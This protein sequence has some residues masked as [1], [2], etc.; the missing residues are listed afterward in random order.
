MIKL[1][2]IQKEY[3]K[4]KEK[5]AKDQSINAK[6]DL[7]N[8]LIELDYVT[9][10]EY[11][12]KLEYDFPMTTTLEK[13]EERLEKLISFIE[14]KSQ[15]Q[16]DLIIEYKKLTGDTI[17]LSYL[18]Y[19]DNIK[20]YKDRLGN[21][22]KILAIIQDIKTLTKNP[23]NK[24]EL[25]VKV[26][27]NRLMKKELQ[28]LLYEF[29]LID[30]LDSKEIELDRLLQTVDIESLP[31]ETT[32]EVE[33]EIKPIELP[34]KEKTKKKE[35]KEEEIFVEEIKEKPQEEIQEY[36]PEEQEGNILT[37]MPKV[38][39]IGSVVPVNVYESLEKAGKKL[40][41]V[42]LPSNG[43]KDDE[44]DIFVDTKNLF[45]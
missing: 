24:N 23:G 14:E 42:V 25:R 3:K 22:R 36:I 21:V 29:C 7:K 45:E 13:E 2:T 8:K 31:E 9:N 4:L 5:Y 44:N 20:S 1:E 39:R 40:P 34:K 17:E 18:K 16:K 38:D 26:V 32:P 30:S 33:E 12:E 43:L 19:S 28:N 15:E 11:E 10:K 35:Q 37:K 41:D 6:E 27:K